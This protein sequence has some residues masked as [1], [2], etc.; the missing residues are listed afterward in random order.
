MPRKEFF[1][2]PNPGDPNGVPLNAFVL[3]PADY[4]PERSYPIIVNIYGGPG[5]QE[6]TFAYDLGMWFGDFLCVFVD[7]QSRRSVMH[8]HLSF[9]NLRIRSDTVSTLTFDQS[10]FKNKT[11]VDKGVGAVKYIL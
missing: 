7:A 4:N 5:S 10:M 1:T 11:R 3:T 6:V 2:I 8:A 9:L